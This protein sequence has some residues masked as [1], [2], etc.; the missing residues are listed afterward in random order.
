MN[1][2]VSLLLFFAA[3]NL[4]AQQTNVEFSKRSFNDKD[5]LQ[6]AIKNLHHGDELY[7]AAFFYYQNEDFS[8][9]RNALPFYSA[10]YDFNPNNAELNFKIG[11]FSINE[12]LSKVLF[13]FIGEFISSI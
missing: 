4:F 8:H 12:R 3:V 13:S 11:V 5:G 10:A 1:K 2:T 9:F 7:K 6:K